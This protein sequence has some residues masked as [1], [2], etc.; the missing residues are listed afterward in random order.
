M[1]GTTTCST[2]IALGLLGSIGLLQAEDLPDLKHPEVIAAGK[3]L[4]QKKQCSTCH[5]ARGDGGVNL[6]KRDLSDS[7]HVFQA[8]AEGREKGGLRM[9]AFREVMSDQEIW[10]TAAFVI[11]ISPTPLTK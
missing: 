7:N 4:F 5:G 6:T 10:L 3:A 1:M 11:S 2:G 8:I 9:P